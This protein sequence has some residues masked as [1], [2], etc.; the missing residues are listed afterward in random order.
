M[1]Y[2]F[3]GVLLAVLYEVAEPMNKTHL[4][5]L[6]AESMEEIGRVQFDVHVPR[7]IHGVF[8]HEKPSDWASQRE[9]QWPEYM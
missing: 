2:S 7:D 6:N 5:I 1:L 4:L 9:E 8:V 3:A